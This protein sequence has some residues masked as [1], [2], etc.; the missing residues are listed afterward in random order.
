MRLLVVFLLFW[1][2]V[3]SA[4]EIVSYEGET[5]DGEP[6]GH[7]TAIMA[8]GRVITGEYRDGG[9]TGSGY[10][11]VIYPSG[12]RY[13]GNFENFLKHG[14]GVHRQPDGLIYSGGW[15]DGLWDGYGAIRGANDFSY[16][17]DFER[18]FADGY[19]IAIYPDCSRYEGQWRQGYQSGSGAMT[20]CAGDVYEGYWL[21]G[22]PHGYGEYTDAQGEIRHGKWFHG[23]YFN[24]PRETA[25]INITPQE[26]GFAAPDWE[27]AEP[28][29]I[30]PVGMTSNV[31][32]AAY[33][34]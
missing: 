13:E 18:G 26:C 7:G 8:D 33:P 34:K 32:H 12:N 3:A 23:C 10:T 11:E 2:G 25:W 14:N 24:P 19:G 20:T 15:S 6:H 1:P 4:S 30:I 21:N 27:N 16:G 28:I 5:L 31:V 29:P 17:G 9:W 22:R